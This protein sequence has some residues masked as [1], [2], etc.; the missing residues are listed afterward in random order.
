MSTD[1]A[2]AV[3]DA[4]VTAHVS[5]ADERASRRLEELIA[6]SAV[7]LAAEPSRAREARANLEHILRTGTEGP[8]EADGPQRLTVEG[9][10][11]AL[12]GI[13]PPP[14]FPICR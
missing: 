12:R 9:L 1:E 8:Y 6:R 10:E 5:D 11:L 7:N 4:V 2:R 13:C 14:V 3:L